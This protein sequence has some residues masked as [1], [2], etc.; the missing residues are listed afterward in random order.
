MDK[1]DSYDLDTGFLYG[2]GTRESDIDDIKITE[3]NLTLIVRK[4][5]EIVDWINEKKDQLL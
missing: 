1:L 2:P 5:N 4:I 3:K